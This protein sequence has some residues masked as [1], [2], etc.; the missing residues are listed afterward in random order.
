MHCN[1]VHK[2]NRFKPKQIK[3][4]NQKHY[5]FINENG[6]KQLLNSRNIQVKVEGKQGMLVFHKCS[7]I[8]DSFGRNNLFAI[9]GLDK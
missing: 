1:P 3:A 8:P 4:G 2:N 9:N 6:F 7:N 5:F